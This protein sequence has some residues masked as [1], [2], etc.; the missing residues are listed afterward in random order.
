MARAMDAV[1]VDRVVVSDHLVFGENLDAYSNPEI[2]GTKADGS[3]RVPMAI[4][5]SL[6]SS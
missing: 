5:L 1:G 4:G 6:S 3:P 2:G